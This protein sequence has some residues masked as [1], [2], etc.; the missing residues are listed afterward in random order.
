MS[1]SRRAFPAPPALVANSMAKDVLIMLTKMGTFEYT[2]HSIRINA[3]TSRLVKMPADEI[4]K[5]EPL[6]LLEPGDIPSLV[7][8]AHDKEAGCIAEQT[9]A[10]D[11]GPLATL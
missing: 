6:L 7:F 11:V 5:M 2:D 9:W 10:V 4:K 3:V 1:P 8:L